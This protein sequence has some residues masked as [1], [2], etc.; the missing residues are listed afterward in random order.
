MNLQIFKSSVKKDT[1][2]DGMY[3]YV[4][5]FPHMYNFVLL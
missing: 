4:A 1:R 3:V 2:Y 5:C